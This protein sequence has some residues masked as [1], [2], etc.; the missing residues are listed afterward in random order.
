MN[1]YKLFLSF[2]TILLQTLQSNNTSRLLFKLVIVRFKIFPSQDGYMI[3]NTHFSYSI[4]IN[5][6]K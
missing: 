5:K 6:C 2:K 3:D 1:F 4:H